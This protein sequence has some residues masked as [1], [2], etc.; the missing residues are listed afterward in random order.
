VVVN[1]VAADD[2]WA[3]L[4]KPVTLRKS[5][6]DGFDRRYCRPLKKSGPSRF[7]AKARQLSSSLVELMKIDRAGDR[8]AGREV[9]S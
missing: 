3:E 4:S 1:E 5:R 2:G 9:R 8:R 7:V 6:E